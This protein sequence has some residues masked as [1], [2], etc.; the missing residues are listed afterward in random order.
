M[1]RTLLAATA[2]A[3][4]LSTP[5]AHAGMD[6]FLGEIMMIGFTYCPRGWAEANGQLMPI[7]QNTALFS[8]LGT[9]FGGDGRSTFGLP[10]LR[11]RV[12]MHV[13]AGPGLPPVTIG[14]VLG[15]PTTTLTTGEL[16]S[17]THQ[18]LATTDN[19]ETPTPL[20]NT[21]AT[22][23]NNEAVYSDYQPNVNM[24]VAAIGHTG[25]NQPFD[26]HQPSLVVRFCIATAGIFP[27][28]P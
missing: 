13:G 16:P 19:N 3:T 6:P 12:A 25:L 20:G 18:L 23:R 10:D 9:A 4:L 5:P 8:L 2:I 17:H 26:Q 27:S 11:G 28:R 1:K 7:A 15:A 21:F 22:Y 14:Q 24:N